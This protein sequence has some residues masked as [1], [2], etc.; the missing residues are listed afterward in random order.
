MSQ[1]FVVDCDCCGGEKD[2]SVPPFRI[3]QP[4]PLKQYGRRAALRA[5]LLASTGSLLAA[6]A[7]TATTPTAA[8]AKP[9]EGPKPSEAPKPTEASKAGAEAPKPTDKPAIVMTTAPSGKPGLERVQLAFCSQVLCILPYEV[10]RRRGLWEGEGL[11]VELVYMRGGAQAMNALLAESI[12]WAGT[13]MDLVV[14]A[15]GKG[16][17]PVMLMST[18]NLPFFALVA[19]PKAG[20]TEIRGLAGKKIGITNLGTTDHLIAQ[21]LL[22]QAG[23]DPNGVE[24]V[25]LGPN[26]YDLLLR[27]EVDAGMVQDP[28]MTLLQRNGGTLLVN[29]MSRADSE[30]YLGGPY[31]FMGLNTRPEV[32]EQKTETARKL[33]RGLL[34]AQQWIRSNPGAEIVKAAPSELVAGGDLGI[35]AESLDKFKN[36]LYP[37]DGRL[38]EK[39]VQQVVQVQRESGVLKD[40]PPFGATDLFT[41][42][43]VQP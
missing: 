4:K 24:F 11:D 25:A 29:L 30:R 16:K 38:E 21:F 19:G 17:K 5:S 1:T 33:V 35:F 3:F 39:S 2:P 18:A 36:D 42:K 20:V 26:L 28:A 15:W 14:Q 13:P 23:V 37:A 41:N 22:K 32:L 9:T 43:L 34:K 12:E 10:A 31:Q 6:C 8:P 7:P 40:A 27:G